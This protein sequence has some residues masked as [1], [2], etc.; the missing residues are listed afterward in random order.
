MGV[1]DAQ[2]FPWLRD[3]IA[4]VER[5]ITSGKPVLGICLGAQIIAAVMGANVYS[6]P[7]KEIGWFPLRAVTQDDAGLFR[8]PDNEIVFHWHGDTFDLPEGAA[9]LAETKVCPN[10][11]FQ[12]GKKVMGL[13]FHLEVTP[14]AARKMVNHGRHELT[15]GAYIQSETEL[16]AAPEVQY[17]NLH[18]LMVRVLEYLMG[19][20]S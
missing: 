19:A 17:E 20:S 4:F 2:E 8:F 5:F 6:G 11:A 15:D 1:H 3:E 7:Q 10:Q 16:L 18:R 9:R 14:E 12:I 13:Q